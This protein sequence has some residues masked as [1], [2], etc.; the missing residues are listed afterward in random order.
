MR[1]S[2]YIHQYP[3]LVVKIVVFDPAT[4]SSDAARTTIFT[5]FG[6]R[7]RRLAWEGVLNSRDLGGYPTADGRETRWGA[8]VRSDNLTTLTEAGR[9][10]LVAYGI[11]SI[12]DLRRP[13]EIQELPSPF[14]VPGTHGIEYTNIPFQDPASPEEAEPETLALIYVGMLNRYRQRVAAVMTAVAQAPNGGVLV[15][16]AGGKDRTGLV[17]AL[18]LSV[19]EVAP[20]TVAADYALSSEYLRPR[21][22]EYLLSG[23]GDRAERE[24]IVAMYR[25]TVEVMLEVLDHL[26]GRSGG[27]ESYLVRAGVAAEDINRLRNRLVPD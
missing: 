22:E 13:S 9:A 21:E 10:A 24:R 25:P 20:E 23:P 11:R 8:V 18:L 1:S 12:I 19:A 4:P 5:T 14:A 16:C 26:N 2:H 17:S 15:H 7:H 6:N 3:T 27:V